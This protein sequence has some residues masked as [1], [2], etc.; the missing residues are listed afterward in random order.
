M[1]FRSFANYRLHL[2]PTRGTRSRSMRYLWRRD[3]DEQ[4][5]RTIR[6]ALRARA[7]T[8]EETAATLCTASLQRGQVAM[9]GRLRGR[10]Q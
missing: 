2:G 1:G 9:I 5:G 7:T 6:E 10:R 3:Y 4:L 8:L